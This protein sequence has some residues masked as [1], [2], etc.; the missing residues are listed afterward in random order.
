M[1]GYK[2]DWEKPRSRSQHL[3]EAEIALLR[4]AF[5]SRRTIKDIARE[6]QCSSRT[7]SKYYGFFRAEGIPQGPQRRPFDP[8]SHRASRF[9]S[10]TFET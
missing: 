6:L 3:T 10:S 1:S 5:S 9:Y 7:V 8:A 2:D 4:K